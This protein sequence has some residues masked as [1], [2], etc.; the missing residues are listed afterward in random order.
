MKLNGI[1]FDMDGTLADTNL[2]CIEAF[3]RTFVHFLGRSYSADEIHALF[4]PDEEGIV[5]RIVPDHWQQAL[6]MY[7][8]E[9]EHAHAAYLQPFGGLLPILDRLRAEGLRLAIVTGKGWGSAEISLRL[10]KLGHY[11]DPIEVGS[12]DGGIKASK[13]RAVL[14]RWAA[15][16]DTVAYLGDALSDVDAARQAGI[17][18]LAAGWCTNADLAGLAARQ[19]DALFR[20]VADFEHWL[21]ENQWT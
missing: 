18:A 6:E 3:Q 4:G 2:V 12:P 7:W 10:L 20:Q 17:T 11:F 1:I 9:Y 16:P 21:E 15:A 14:D 13:I 5:R 8:R 19:P